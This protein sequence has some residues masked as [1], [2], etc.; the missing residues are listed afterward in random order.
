MCVIAVC[1][2][3][4]LSR[5]EVKAIWDNNPHG[6]GATW[7]EGNE[8]LYQKGFMKRR[9]FEEFYYGAKLPFPHVVHFRWATHGGVCQELTH[10]Y[11]CDKHGSL[12]LSY[13]GTQSALFHNGVFVQWDAALKILGDNLGP[14]WAE[15]VDK[16]PMSDSRVLALVQAL[17]PDGLND[18]SHGSRV[19]V[20]SVKTMR[21]IGPF[22]NRNG[23]KFSS[24]AWLPRLYTIQ[25]GCKK[26][27]VVT[28]AVA[29]IH[30][31]YFKY[32]QDRDDDNK[33]FTPKPSFSWPDK[34]SWPDKKK[35]DTARRP[36]YN[37]FANVR[38]GGK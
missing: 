19:A 31:T 3:R 15:K 8:V 16:L 27:A 4:R 6:A 34:N 32:S 12:P 11:L 30:P 21:L 20:F 14:L 24:L 10:P 17:S 38:Y 28:A 37:V 1:Q 5:D 18:C 29:N 36:D 33:Y 2:K 22:E 7:R 13:K 25:H 26:S 35:I 9:D 23:V